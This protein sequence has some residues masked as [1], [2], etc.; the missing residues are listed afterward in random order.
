MQKENF[1]TDQSINHLR[2]KM[3]SLACFFHQSTSGVVVTASDFGFENV[4]S[5]PTWDS[6]F[7]GFFHFFYVSLHLPDV[8]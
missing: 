7:Y 6:F 2:I 8:I 4:G 1:I 3:Q 5:N